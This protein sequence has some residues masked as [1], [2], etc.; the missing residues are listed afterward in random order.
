MRKAEPVPIK[1][2]VKSA[3]QREAPVY[4]VAA[5]IVLLWIVYRVGVACLS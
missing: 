2:I 4:R 1:T 3:A 5:V